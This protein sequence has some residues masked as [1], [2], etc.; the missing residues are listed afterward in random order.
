MA[1][2]RNK[3]QYPGTPN[4][5][6]RTRTV[7][8]DDDVSMSGVDSSHTRGRHSPNRGRGRNKP[9]SS[10][11]GVNNNNP[12]SILS[13]RDQL[14]QH[15]QCNNHGQGGDNNANSNFIASPN[16]KRK[17][18]RGRGRGRNNDLGITDDDDDLGADEN[19][20]GPNTPLFPIPWPV[21]N[22]S[23]GSSGSN[24]VRFCTECSTS[25]RANLRF[26]NWAARAL[27]ACGERV[28]AWAE[29]VG[30]GFGCADEMDWQ[31][32]PVIRVLL[33]AQ[34][35]SG[36]SKGGVLQQQEYE[37][38]YQ[39]RVHQ[40]QQ[41]DQRIGPVP[42]PG[43]WPWPPW[44]NAGAT[45]CLWRAAPTVMRPEGLVELDPATLV[46]TDNIRVAIDP[47][48]GGPSLIGGEI[49]NISSIDL[50]RAGLSRG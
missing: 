2:N 36:A 50:S 35:G 40:N 8:F 42:T 7:D 43:P 37:R 30:V 46:H 49:P 34:A 26:R 48:A 10:R 47:R 20:F 1:R 19:L 33:L 6:W 29:E 32:E 31:P 3:N 13:I 24:N 12:F 18:R 9:G 39:Q 22:T 25:R 44:P 21:L 23:N 14:P 11:Q 38:E 17:R 5:R 41:G 15:Q 27:Q 45:G 28:A 16:N 4:S